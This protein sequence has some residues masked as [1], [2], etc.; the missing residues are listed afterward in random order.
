MQR[1]Y[2]LVV[3]HLTGIHRA[4]TELNNIQVCQ[5]RTD[6]F[7]RCLATTNMGSEPSAHLLCD[8]YI[9]P[10]LCTSNC[11]LLLHLGLHKDF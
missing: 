11:I 2:V 9:Y 8:A 6:S 7:Y 3:H 10:S 5:K 4:I 1:A